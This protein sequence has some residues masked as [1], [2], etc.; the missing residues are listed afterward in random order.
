MLEIASYHQ[1]PFSGAFQDLLMCHKEERPLSFTLGQISKR[2][3]STHQKTCT[4]FSTYL[5]PHSG[6]TSLDAIKSTWLHHSQVGFVQG[7]VSFFPF[8]FFPTVHSL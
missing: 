5:I 3:I 7:N 1:L 6:L 2:Q 4:E 8:I